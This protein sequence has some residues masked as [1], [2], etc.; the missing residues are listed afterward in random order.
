MQY[1]TIVFVLLLL[2]RMAFPPAIRCSSTPYSGSDLRVQGLRAEFDGLGGP[3]TRLVAECY[4]ESRAVR[5][6]HAAVPGFEALVEQR[7]QPVEVLHPRFAR[8]GGG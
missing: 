3:G 7:R 8:V 2:A 5:Y 1:L 6:E 4:A